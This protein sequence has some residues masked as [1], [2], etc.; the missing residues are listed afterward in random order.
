MKKIIVASKN[1]V[2]INAVKIGFEKVFPDD[3]FEFEGISVPSDVSEQPKDDQETMLG[4]LSRANNAS[5]AT[6]KADYWV[7]IEGGIQ[8]YDK[9]MESFS[10]IVIKSDSV[11]GKAKTGTFFLPFEIVKMINA[12]KEL[13]QAGDIVFGQ[14][15]LKQKGGAVGLLTDNIIDRTN[16]YSEAVVLALIPFKNPK[17][18]NNHGNKK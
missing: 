14:T 1:P 18:Y 15:N 8:K 6:S 3:D 4:A 2:K 11:I 7:G 12:G 10:W 5:S 13:G 17:L 9:E 16:F